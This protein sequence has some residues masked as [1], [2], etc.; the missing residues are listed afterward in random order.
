[1]PE[2]VLYRTHDVLV[3]W[4]PAR[5]EDMR[6]REGSELAPVSGKRFPLPALVW[7][8]T[9]ATL[10]VRALAESTRPQPAT[11]L[12]IAPFWNTSPS[13]GVICEGSMRRPRGRN[14]AAIEQWDDAF[15]GSEF[16]HQAGAG[17]LARTNYAKLLKRLV[18]SDE[19]PADELVESRQTLASFALSS[20]RP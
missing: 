16:T 8:L 7:R 12:H 1:L 10:A 2:A 18:G 4:T 5:Q 19:Y 3:W 15:F 17:S 6:F 14:P 20:G 13:D 11:V 9:A